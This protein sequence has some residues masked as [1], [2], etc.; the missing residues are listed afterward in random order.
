MAFSTESDYDSISLSLEDAI[1]FNRKN[2]ALL[3][4]AAYTH[5]RVDVFYRD[6]TETKRTVDAMVGVTQV[7]DKNTLF[8]ANL[9]LGRVEGFIG[10]PYK[11]AELNG[12]L[13]PEKRPDE[14][15][16]QILFLSIA[17]HLHAVDA[18]IE[19]AYRYYTDSFGIQADTVELAWYQYLGTRWILRPALRYYQQSAAEFYGVRF[20]GSPEYY[21][22]DYRLSDMDTLGYGLKLIWMANDRLVFDAAFDRYV[23]EGRD[24]MTADEVYPSANVFTVGIGLWL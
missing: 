12:I 2:T 18:S 6:R 9:S 22:A 23:M 10:D 11:V 1:D 16:K 5:D 3:V 15:D 7:L 13:V 4:G 24:G 14:K 17:R 19:A 8:T 21:S 20:S